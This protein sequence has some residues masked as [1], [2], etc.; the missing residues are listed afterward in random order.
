L[1]SLKSE[2]KYYQTAIQEAKYQ[3]DWLNNERSRLQEDVNSCNQALVVY[4]KLFDI[5]FGLKEL[6]LLW[7]AICEISDANNIRREDVVKKFFKDIE[8][9]YDYKV[10]F[11][12]KKH[13]LQEEVNN[14]IQKKRS[15]LEL[16]AILKLA[17]AVAKLFSVGFNNNIQEFILLVGKICMA[18]GVRAA[19][20]ILTSQPIAAAAADRSKSPV[21]LSNNSNSYNNVDDDGTKL[22]V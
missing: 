19:I 22:V 9:H 20:D 10:G 21:F 7:H 17:A 13:K 3:C 1:Q 14:L 18:G 16:I 6:K 11:E 2:H 8:D 15:S 12:S 5:E 4:G